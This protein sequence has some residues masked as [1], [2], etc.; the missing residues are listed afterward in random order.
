MDRGEYINKMKEAIVKMGAERVIKDLNE[1]FMEKGSK[2]ES[3]C[4][5]QKWNMA[6]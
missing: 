4:F 6:G 2:M 1:V 3:K 5:N